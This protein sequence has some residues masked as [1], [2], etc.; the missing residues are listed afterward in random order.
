MRRLD[1][2][3]RA[4]VVLRY[5]LGLPTGTPVVFDSLPIKRWDWT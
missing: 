2:D 3:E 5:F 1:Q 4:V